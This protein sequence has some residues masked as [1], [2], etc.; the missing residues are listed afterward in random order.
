MPAP[1]QRSES[2]FDEA[3]ASFLTTDLLGLE[4]CGQNAEEEGD[5]QSLSEH[6][7]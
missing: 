2:G 5:S 7:Q 6:G 3:Y 1:H 4:T